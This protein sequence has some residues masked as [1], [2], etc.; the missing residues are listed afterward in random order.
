MDN[1][2]VTHI[3]IYTYTHRQVVEDKRGGDGEEED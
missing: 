3:Y 2:D 1:Y